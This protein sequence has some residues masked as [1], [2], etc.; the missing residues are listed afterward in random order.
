MLWALASAHYSAGIKEEHLAISKNRLISLI[1]FF[2]GEQKALYIFYITMI[3][4]NE[5]VWF[6]WVCD[7]SACSAF[8]A[9]VGV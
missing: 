1:S 7:C 8:A 4:W 6:S 2:E 9:A 5:A 3:S